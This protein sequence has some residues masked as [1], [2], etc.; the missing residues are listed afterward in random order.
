MA[1]WQ[2]QQPGVNNMMS[3]GMQGLEVRARRQLGAP[4]I[5]DQMLE[6][7]TNSL[8]QNGM[9]SSNVIADLDLSQ[10]KL[11]HEQWDTLFAVLGLQECRVIR[12]RLFGCPTLDDN[13]AA[14]LADYLRQVGP[15]RAPSEMHLSDCA[16]TSFGFTTIIS[17]LEETDTYPLRLSPTRPNALYLRLENNYISE[18]AIKEKV[19]AGVVFAYKKGPGARGGGA[20]GY[21]VDLVLL[22]DHGTYNQRVGSPPGP[23]QARPPKQVNDRNGLLAQQQTGV[24]QTGMYQMQGW[25]QQ[26]YGLQAAAYAAHQHSAAT[27]FAGCAGQAVPVSLAGGQF[28]A[29]GF[30]HGANN[31]AAQCTGQPWP[32]GNSG[33]AQDRSRTPVPQAVTVAS[34]L[35]PPP[36]APEVDLPKPWEKHWSDEYKIPYYWHPV[37]GE[38]VW[39][40]PIS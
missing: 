18:A 30:R 29:M 20:N 16:I 10:N 8:T 1:A 25:Q 37:T 3:M 32:R 5:F 2:Q 9:G 12:F 19:D 21:K 17:A 35:P 39:E 27:A 26:Q 28:A 4:A 34:K 24:T 38:S 14:I 22:G 15:H 31:A 7:I 11:T 13:V 40:K 23:D 36:A 33:T 6:G